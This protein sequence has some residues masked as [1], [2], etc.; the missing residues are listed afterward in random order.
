VQPS[1]N[2]QGPRPGLQTRRHDIS[3]ISVISFF[4]Y[5][6]VSHYPEFFCKGRGWCTNH[7]AKIGNADLIPVKH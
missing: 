1:F 5:Q 6:A 2:L 4:P 7:E 3:F